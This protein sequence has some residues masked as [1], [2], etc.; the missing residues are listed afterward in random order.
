MGVRVR[1]CVCV[2]VCEG[3]RGVVLFQTCA[4]S[5]ASLAGTLIKTATPTRVATEGA[6][7]ARGVAAIGVCDNE[8]DNP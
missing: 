5:A 4:R 7:L 6:K 8:A 3:E 1:V 2:R